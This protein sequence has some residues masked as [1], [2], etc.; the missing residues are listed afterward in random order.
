MTAVIIIGK[1]EGANEDD[2]IQR[3]SS[4]SLHQN[5]FQNVHFQQFPVKSRMDSRAEIRFTALIYSEFHL[6]RF[7]DQT[8]GTTDGKSNHKGRRYSENFPLFSLANSRPS[9][10][11]PP[12]SGTFGEKQ[13]ICQCL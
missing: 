13:S 7:N 8:F 6:A 11:A 3:D 12:G 9:P 10:A 4:R 5:H 1:E 2:E